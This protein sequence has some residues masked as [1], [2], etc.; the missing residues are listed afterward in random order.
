[1]H[2]DFRYSGA[3]PEVPV[4]GPEELPCQHGSL[5]A[6]SCASPLCSAWAPVVAVIQDRGRTLLGF[7]QEEWLAD[8]L[9]SAE[10]I[11]K[12]TGQQAIL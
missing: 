10:G 6:R 12:V 3:V 9:R 8:Q 1:V 7:D 11:C 2:L 5:D 4:P